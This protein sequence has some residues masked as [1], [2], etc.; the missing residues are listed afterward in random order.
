MKKCLRDGDFLACYC[1]KCKPNLYPLPKDYFKDMKF[2]LKIN[3]ENLIPVCCCGVV[4][5]NDEECKKR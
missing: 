5:C 4:D 2:K 3:A 1:G